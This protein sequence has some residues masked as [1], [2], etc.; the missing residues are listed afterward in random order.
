MGVVRGVI[1][2]PSWTYY[3]LGSYA[4]LGGL[5]LEDA[6]F[7]DPDPWGRI[8]PESARSLPLSRFHG[9][10]LAAKPTYQALPLPKRRCPIEQHTL[11]FVLSA[12]TCHPCFAV[13]PAEQLEESPESDRVALR[14]QLEA[15]VRD[16]GEPSDQ[17]RTMLLAAAGGRPCNAASSRGDGAAGPRGHPGAARAGGGLIHTAVGPSRKF[18]P[19][20]WA[21]TSSG[22]PGAMKLAA[23]PP[24][25]DLSLQQLR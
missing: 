20:G 16:D 8:A 23:P 6:G 21:P 18:K 9:R 4:S 19:Q 3:R 25:V 15:E 12:Q 22:V 5:I 7:F 14:D 2:D 1:C 17:A 10:V 24:R 11:I 13:A